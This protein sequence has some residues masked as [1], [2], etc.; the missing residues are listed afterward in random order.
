MK[1]GITLLLFACSISLSFSQKI[2]VYEENSTFPVAG[3]AV[4]NSDKSQVTTTDFNGVVDLS[5]FND[6]ETIFFQHIAHQTISFVK[7]DILKNHLKI[8]LPV[9]AN[10]L[11]EVVLSASKFGQQ[12]KDVPQQIVS[13]SSKDIQFTNPQTAADLLESSGQVYVQKSQLGGG[14][15]MIRGFSTNRLLIAVDGIRFNTAIFRGGNVQNIISVDPFT[16]EHT[17]IILGPGSIIYGS[18][19][20][21]GVI[22]FYTKKPQLSYSDDTHV[23]GSL[24]SRY[25]TANSEKTAHLDLNVAKKNWGFLTSISFSDFDDLQMGKKGPDEYLRPQYVLPNTNGNDQVLSNSNPRKQLFTGYSQLNFMQKIRYIPNENWDFNLGLFY[26][27]TSDIPRYDRLIQKTNDDDF[28]YAEWYYGPQKWLSGNI[29][30]SH[31]GKKWYDKGLLTLSHQ[32]F[33][34]SRNKRNL[35]QTTFFESDEEVNAYTVALDFSK[36]IKKNKLFYG[37][38]YVY[39]KIHSSATK[40]D[41]L[42]GISQPDA[43]RY[44]DNSSWQS[45][46]VYSSFLLKFSEKAT[47]QTGIRYNHIIINANLETPFYDFPFSQANLNTGALTG[48]A[49]LSWQPSK[50]LAWKFNFSTAFRAPNIDDIGKIFDSEPGSVVVPNP[51]LKPE[52]AYNG[53]IAAILNFNNNLKITIATYLTQLN[54]A[55]VRRDFSLNGQTIID[56]QGEPSTIQA[57]QNG[58]SAMIQGF[59]FG[60]DAKLSNTLQF[61][62]QYSVADG[63][64]KEENGDKVPVRHVAPAFANAHFIWKKSK[65]KIDAFIDYNGTHDFEDMAPSEIAKPFLYLTDKNGNPY[66][67]SWY[68]LNLTSQYQ[69]TNSLQVTTSLENITNQRYRPYSSGITAPGTNLIVS[70]LYAF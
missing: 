6:E 61:T 64:Q 30:V 31:T 50:T 35:N 47:F 69:L 52:Y 36:N 17:E 11:E 4:Y 22:N 2:T 18:D 65:L 54:N 15:P 10:A 33:I 32:R 63:L 46:A 27:T 13:I 68:T 39:N 56:Y 25:A 23:S 48:S 8:Y 62:V 29:Q 16:I 12:K 42:A 70:L 9:S 38:E 21:G 1:E 51:N 5:K 40:T 7:K 14:S 60:V 34:E 3:V 41:L 49:G 24:V 45:M 53:E 26:T 43:P 55:L 28:K 20:I 66:S 37:F 59:E 58:G 19:A 44:P 67:P 57:I